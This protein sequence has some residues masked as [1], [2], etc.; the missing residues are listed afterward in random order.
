MG[1]KDN[2]LDGHPE[3]FQ[4]G[5]TLGSSPPIYPYTYLKKGPFI[6]EVNPH[7]AQHLTP[8]GTGPSAIEDFSSQKWAALRGGFSDGVL[9]EAPF[10]FLIFGPPM[11][12]SCNVHLKNG[13]ITIECAYDRMA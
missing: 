13:V 12:L 1:G 4:K 6:F 8:H 10:Q 5:R 11:L 9:E 3:H 2:I 7:L